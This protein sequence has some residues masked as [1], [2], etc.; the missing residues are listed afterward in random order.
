LLIICL[1]GFFG[2][3]DQTINSNELVL[4]NM[5]QHDIIPLQLLVELWYLVS[6]SC[7]NDW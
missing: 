7:T 3:I 2:D 4:Y 1:Y 6:V 5:I